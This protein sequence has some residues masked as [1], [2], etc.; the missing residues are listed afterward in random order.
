MKLSIKLLVILFVLSANHAFADPMKMGTRLYFS[1]EIRTV[2]QAAKQILRPT[3]YKLLLTEPAPY[4]SNEIASHPISKNALS[5]NVLSIEDALLRLVGDENRVI[6][7]HANKLVS[8][9]YHDTYR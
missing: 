7:D 3:G 4:E 8:F 1:S 5:Q 6:I 2:G 9:E